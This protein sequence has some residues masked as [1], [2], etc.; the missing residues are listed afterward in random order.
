VIAPAI[1]FAGRVDL[2]ASSDRA[3]SFV[4]TVTMLSRH[5]KSRSPNAS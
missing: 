4:I 1:H 2:I 5:I 3:P